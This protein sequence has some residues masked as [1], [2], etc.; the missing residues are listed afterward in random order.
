MTRQ[1]YVEKKFSPRSLE[2]IAT[3]E[4]ICRQYA[5]QGFDLTL[6]QLYYQFVARD[7][8]PNK[9]SEY[10]NLG[11]V[12]N[13]ARLAGLLDWD[14]IVDRTRNLRGLSHW[15][16]PH[17]VIRS[18][19]SGYRTERWANQP[20]RIEVWIEKDALV[21]VITGVCQR[22]DVDYFSC[23]GYT[24]QS[25]LWGAAQRMIRYQ[26]AGQKPVI[27]HLGD[28]DPSGVDMTRDIRERLQLFEA[29]V[30]VRRIALNM[31]QVEEHQP[32]PNPAKL[33]DSR[34]SGYIRAHG[35]SSW[36]LDAL[37]PTLL[38]Q[39]IEEEIW[40]WRD[41]DL[42]DEATHAMERE[43]AL[44]RAVATRWDEVADLVSEGGEG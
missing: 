18:A 14:Y 34:A 4:R 40:A 44:L 15:D 9:Q 30:E 21:G 36:E 3:A 19:A 38:D 1:A 35:R 26:R 28:H 8:I 10:K 16:N 33:T 5:E 31:D 25:E 17:S 27:I 11:N 24:S 2:L 43:R 6:R 12:I 41:L 42:W 32:P 13:N 7:L 37:Q 39:L 22:Y 23:R 29:D 20:H